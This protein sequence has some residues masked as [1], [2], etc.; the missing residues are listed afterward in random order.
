MADGDNAAGELVF[1]LEVD[2]SLRTEFLQE[3]ARS[4]SAIVIMECGGRRCVYYQHWHRWG[5]DGS[6]ED[7]HVMS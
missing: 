4:S 6:E 5:G 3:F 2:F 1:G 7:S